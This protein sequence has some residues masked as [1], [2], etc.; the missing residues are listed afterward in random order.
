MSNI[1]I[2]NLHPAGSDLFSD[3]ESYMTDVNDLESGQV[4]GG[5]WTPIWVLSGASTITIGLLPL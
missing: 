4:N 5:F 3:S 1:T 2:T